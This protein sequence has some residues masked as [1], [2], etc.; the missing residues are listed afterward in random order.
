VT[1]REDG[2]AELRARLLRSGVLGQTTR[3]PRSFGQRDTPTS[4]VPPVAP[5]ESLVDGTWVTG[6][7]GRCFVS[8]H[9]YPLDHAH[10]CQPLGR[11][12]DLPDEPWLPYLPDSDPTFQTR[13]A[14]FLDTETT[15]LARGAGTLAF[16]AGVG[17][18]RDNAFCVRQYFLPGF[19]DE[20]V[21][22]GL[23]AE[24]FGN[25]GGLVT[26]NGR[27]F[28]WPILETRYV[29]NRQPP[30]EAGPHL[31]L[32]LL[33]RRLWRRTQ[34]SCALGALEASVMNVARTSADV[35][36]YLIP[37]LYQDYLHGG[38]AEPMAQV[39]YHNEI[40]ILSMVTLAAQMGSILA[41]PP[42][43]G[44]AG[45]PPAC[46]HVSL[47]IMYEQT[48]Q[49]GRALDAYRRAVNDGTQA[50]LVPLAWKRLSL[51][52]KRIGR[53][54]EAA[55]IWGAQLG[56]GE[57]Y[58]FIELAKHHEH[59]S[60]S[61][62]EAK[63]VVDQGIAWAE[64]TR[65]LDSDARDRLMAD[66]A[67]RAARLERKLRREA[68]RDGGDRADTAP[69]PAVASPKEQSVGEADGD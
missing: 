21:L 38:P 65:A 32:L 14:L 22:L 17:M 53:Y 34:P 68:S 33:A 61:L 6:D 48:G 56:R 63:R 13:R 31:D 39:F 30:P 46:D 59:R 49:T 51:L 69:R 23:L 67:Y 18:F 15:G 1:S 7:G 44:I 16:M 19:G 55:A 28:D 43:Q 40:D 52:L 2:L 41:R 57:A 25:A 3:T 50:A 4:D 24:D 10:G 60:K 29:L 62:A 37:Q 54:D 64:Q 66:L 11:L 12:L 45:E 8:E 42:A 58:P 5:I 35:P 26:F 27:S 9:V 20:Q 47:G 36:G